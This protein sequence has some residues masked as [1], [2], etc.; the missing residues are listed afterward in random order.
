M[1]SRNLMDENAIPAHLK[2]KAGPKRSAL[3]PIAVKGQ[4][5]AVS[6][7]LPDGKAGDC[8]AVG[9]G[10]K[11]RLQHLQPVAKAAGIKAAPKNPSVIVKPVNGTI[12][13]ATAPTAAT[14]FSIFCDESCDSE[15]SQDGVL[16][17]SLGG[18]GDAGSSERKNDS[19]C[20][21]F[22]AVGVHDRALKELNL[23]S[24]LKSSNV[25]SEGNFAT[26]CSMRTAGKSSANKSDLNMSID[27]ENIEPVY[28]KGRQSLA[29]P[30]FTYEEYLSDVLSYLL[31]VEKVHAVDPEAIKQQPEVNQKMR[32]VLV[33]WLI[34]VAD[35]YKLDDETLFLAVSFIDR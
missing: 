13:I 16:D 28:K 31:S 26:P 23:D 34:E 33:D 21:V 9:K 35:E 5:N 10:L 17:L 7:A 2:A 3:C 4:E 32:I 18:K 20:D 8:G 6:K 29:N 25:S 27:A 1:D 15:A 30:V 11:N 24:S 14:E 19:V 22:E 12:T